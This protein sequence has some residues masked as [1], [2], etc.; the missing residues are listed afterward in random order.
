MPAG[1]RRAGGGDFKLFR[2]R[3][4]LGLL[5]E[6]EGGEGHAASSSSTN[7]ASPRSRAGSISTADRRGRKMLGSR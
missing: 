3:H 6:I 1:W 5:A 2:L 4:E 7:S